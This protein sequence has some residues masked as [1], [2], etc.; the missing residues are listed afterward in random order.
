MQL[1]SLNASATPITSLSVLRGMPLVELRMRWCQQITD[2][3]PLTQCPTLE[4]I[5]LPSKAKDIEFLRQFTKLRRISYAEH[6]KEGSTTFQPDKTAEQFWK[7]YDA[8]NNATRPQ[9]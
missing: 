6:L 9:P 7:E 1:R 8:K 4:S 5:T 3:S 2:L